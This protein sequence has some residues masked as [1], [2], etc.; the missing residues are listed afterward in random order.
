MIKKMFTKKKQQQEQLLQ[1]INELKEKNS[2]LNLYI[3]GELEKCYDEIDDFKHNFYCLKKDS[4]N[5]MTKTFVQ[6][7]L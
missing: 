4:L 6:Y 1:E 2:Q 3:D 5:Y 7:L